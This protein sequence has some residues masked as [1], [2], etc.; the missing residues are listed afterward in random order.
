MGE[1]MGTMPQLR[2][3]LLPRAR[4]FRL[5]ANRA[6]SS[7]N[8]LTAAAQCAARPLVERMENRLLLSAYTLKELA[9]LGTN[10]TGVYPQSA[11]VADSSGNLY[12]TTVQGGA[13]GVGTVFD[14]ASGSGTIT[15]LG[16]FNGINGEAPFAGVS[17]D[18]SGNLYGTTTNGGA[19]NDGTVF[20]LAKGSGAITALASFEGIDVTFSSGVTPDGAGNLYGAITQD[21]ASN[22]GAVFEVARGSN[23]VTTVAEFNGTDGA[24]PNSPLTLDASGNL[25][26]TTAQGGAGYPTSSFGTVF[27][28]A[29]GSKT[30]TTLASFDPLGN[31]GVRYPVGG[32]TLD[33]SGNLYGAAGS[34]TNN[35]PDAGSVFELPKSSAV[36]TAVAS[37]SGS[38]GSFPDAGLTLDASGNLYGTTYSGG[39]NNDGTIFEIAAGSTAVTTIAS[40]DNTN[41]TNDS[42]PSGLTRD[43]S[44]NLFG[45]TQ[46]GGPTGSGVVFE[47]AAGTNSITT[48]ASFAALDGFAPLGPLTLDASG[49]LYGTT[50]YG[51]ADNY[52]TIFELA[53]GSNVETT[54]ASFN[55]NV[56]SDAWGGVTLDASGNFYGTAAGNAGAVFEMAAGSATITTLAAFAPHAPVNLSSLNVV[57]DASGNIYG[58]T[59]FG[60][61]DPGTVFE[62]AKGSSAMTTV[63]VF[64]AAAGQDPFGTLSQDASGDLFGM[65]QLAGASGDGTVYELPKGS[66]AVTALASFNTATGDSPSSLTI[67]RSG[68]L[69]GATSKGG[70]NGYGTIFEIPEGSTIITVLASFDG[71]NEEGFSR[72]TP[73]A[74]GNLFGITDGL[75]ND[76]GGIFEIAKESN[77]ITTLVSFN[78]GDGLYPNPLTPDGLGNFYGTT[79]FGGLSGEGTIF[80]LT[81]NTTATLKAAGG[82]NPSTVA[83][84]LTFAATVTRGVPDGE[85][86]SLI[87]A[88]NNN[89]VVASGTISNGSAALT[90]PAGA[91][92]PGTHKLIAAYA[93]NAN[94]AACQSVP[95]VQTVNSDPL[96]SYIIPSAGAAYGYNSVTGALNLTSGTLTFTADN[97]AAPLVN[98]TSSGPASGVFFDAS[99]HLAGLTMTGGAQATVLSLGSARTH[100]NHDVLV[101]GSPGSASDPAFSIDPSSKLDLTDNDLIVHTGSTDQGNGVPNQLG[102]PRT[103]DLSAVRSLALRGRNVVAGGVLDGTWTGNG[104]TSSSA[105][106]ADAAGGYEQNVLAVVQNSDQ[107]LGKL[108]A[109]TVGSFSEPLGSNDILVKYTYNG[110]SALEGYVGTDSVTIVNDFYDAGK[111]TQNDWAFGDF[112][113]NGK[114]DDNDITILNG[115]YG[116][117]TA[118]SGLPQL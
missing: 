99:E 39:T 52:G 28:I 31:G 93:G 83:Q 68:N 81:A 85:T 37:F 22:D 97:T 34:D 30:I 46:E 17:L 49:D 71:I 64:N 62:I 104:L 84:P 43:A 69:Y 92:M 63:A 87:D 54:L 2:G 26:G 38:N 57:F 24:G 15:T 114:V 109:W 3:L 90:V 89:A 44:G 25:Y 117:G 80:E 106:S 98:L 103:N 45:T 59:D 7:G 41:N 110:D 76:N 91:L 32:V 40:F 101:I 74:S 50:V 56:E 60:S 70:A 100:A 66:N 78:Y 47:V 86:V 36:I 11:L 8:R 16:S 48:R 118:A 14:I 65:T 21:G 5:S 58:T 79:Q 111:A 67:D 4:R 1:G 27:E 112:T 105:A 51:G 94:F 107:M 29:R 96:P 9:L 35:S 88:S 72:V 116:N 95:F 23:L 108:S 13:Y 75:G 82:P 102:I 113:G 61:I 10:S 6:A 55:G 12:G 33:S 18:R 73:D 53:A 19:N 42:R 20:E 77:T 115:L